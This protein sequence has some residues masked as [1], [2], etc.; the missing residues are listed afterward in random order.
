MLLCL[1]VSAQ[2][3]LLIQREGPGQAAPGAGVGVW[4]LVSLIASLLIA[5][6]HPG[7]ARPQCTGLSA[8][9]LA[10]MENSPGAWQPLP[11]GQASVGGRGGTCR[12]TALWALE[13]GIKLISER[14]RS[15]GMRTCQCVWASLH[16]CPCVCVILCVR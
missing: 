3:L 8:G 2:K 12:R 5:V 6:P 4:V 10:V 9:R 11:S 13:F 14:G 7:T 1:C 16:V 15:V